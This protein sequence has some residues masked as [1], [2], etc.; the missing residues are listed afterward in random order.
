MADARESYPIY[1][2][3]LSHEHDNLNQR[4]FWYVFSQAF[5]FGA[6]ASVVNAP[7]VAKSAMFAR[8]QDL[9]VWVM[10]ITAILISGLIYPLILISVRYMRELSLKFERI[11]GGDLDDLPPIHGNPTLRHVG[12]LVH[13]SLPAILIA[14]WV[15]I[16]AWQFRTG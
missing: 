9:L 16:L 14:I 6:Y 8:Q 3:Q 13:Q 5:L 11:A 4:T 2:G 12:D 1:Q 10:P 15:L 7:Q